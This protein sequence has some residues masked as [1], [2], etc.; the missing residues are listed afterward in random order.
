MNVYLVSGEWSWEEDLGDGIHIF[1]L[2]PITVP[3]AAQTPEQ[4]RTLFCVEM[5]DEYDDT[6]S[7]LIEEKVNHNEG[8]LWDYP[9]KGSPA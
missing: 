6:Q 4:A 1:E 3:V 9:T 2:S 8:I 7:R 5:E